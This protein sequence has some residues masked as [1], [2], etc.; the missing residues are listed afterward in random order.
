MEVNV[1]NEELK[2]L[3]EGLKLSGV[4]KG[5]RNKAVSEKTGYS[6]R[7]VGSILS[8]HAALTQRFVQ[9]VC[10]AFGISR[11]WVESG[12]EATLLDSYGLEDREGIVGHHSLSR[13]VDPMGLVI[14]KP[15]FPTRRDPCASGDVAALPDDA[16]SLDA[17]TQEIVSDMKKLTESNR[18][19]FVGRI[20]PIIQAMIEEQEVNMI[21]RSG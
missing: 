5:G 18:W 15:V 20:K 13:S 8:G 3:L 9:A 11:T 19:V 14:G 6:L 2:R 10:S 16:R 7:S 1:E 17:P 21:N 4:I 12:C